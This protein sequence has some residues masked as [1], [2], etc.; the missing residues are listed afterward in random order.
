LNTNLSLLK[1]FTDASG[2]VQVVMLLL[3]AI[4]VVSWTLIFQ[5]G[6]ALHQARQAFALFEQRFQTLNH[7]LNKLYDHLA[8]RRIAAKGAEQVF[9]LGFREFVRLYKQNAPRADIL[10]GSERAMRVALAREEEQLEQHLPFLATVGS[11]SVYVGLFGTVWGIMTAFRALGSVQQATLAMVAPGIAEALIATALGLF[12]AIP[13]VFAY[14]RFSSQSQQLIRGYDTLAEEFCGALHRRLHHAQEG[15][16]DAH[17]SD[18]Q[19]ADQI[20]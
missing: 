11:L 5:R 6:R 17:A 13:A 14:N 15:K 3:L 7:D 2:L 1:L 9:R 10:S 12:A 19:A 8:S 20:V 18:F 16:N 4:S